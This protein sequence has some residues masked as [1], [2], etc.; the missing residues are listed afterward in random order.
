M[1]NTRI[2]SWHCDV[3]G[4][5]RPDSQISVLSKPIPFGQY[6]IK[7]CNDRVECLEGAKKKELFGAETKKT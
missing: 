5:E 6:N 7:Y 3:C 1:I 4:T 2:I